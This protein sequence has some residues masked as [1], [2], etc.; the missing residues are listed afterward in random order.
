MKKFAIIVLALAVATIWAGIGY[1]QQ[2]SSQQPGAPSSQQ[3]SSQQPGSQQ[4]PAAGQTGSEMGKTISGTVKSVDPANKT[5]TVELNKD[6]GNKKKGETMT[7]HVGD[8]VKW[9][10]TQWKS[11]TDIK[12][13]QTIEFQ[14]S[15]AAGG[16]HEI[17][18]FSGAMGAGEG[19]GAGQTGTT[20][21]QGRSQSGTSE[22]GTPSGSQ[23]R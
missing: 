22:Q 23:N 9:E 10:G 16:K 8:K 11:L 18:S 17:Q 7:F 6:W 20:T 4:Q 14:A 13:G 12:P 21:E 5:I 2:P 3:P 1:A 19:R 15:E